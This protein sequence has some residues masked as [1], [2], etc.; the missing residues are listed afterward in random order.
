MAGAAAP[1][2]YLL[3]P[4]NCPKRN[5]SVQQR[6]R[7]L[8]FLGIVLFIGASVSLVMGIAFGGAVYDW[9]SGQIIGLFVCTGIPWILFCLQQ[10]LCVLTNNVDRLFP[11][12]FLKSYEMCILFAQIAT[13]I[14]CMFIPVYFIP[15]FFQ[16]VRND[17]ALEACV[18]LLP[19]VFV[20]VF[21]GM[22]NGAVI[23]RYGFYM[24]W[25]TAGGVLVTIGGALLNSINLGS[26]AGKVYGI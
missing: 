20:T 13:C 2:Y 16:F 15:L 11:V 6:I 5:S 17:S 12:Q 10:L 7:R 23:E 26:N 8:D 19:F 22:I 4:S 18:R 9:R 14:A 21:G 1:A 3:L 25:F 24:P